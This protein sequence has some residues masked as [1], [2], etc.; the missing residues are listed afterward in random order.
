MDLTFLL[1]YCAHS[2]IQFFSDYIIP[3]LHSNILS[4]SLNIVFA[5]CVTHSIR[6]SN[7]MSVNSL[8]FS[9]YCLDELSFSKQQGIFT[10]YFFFLTSK[11][12]YC[13]TNS[14]SS[15]SKWWQ[16]ICHTI[17]AFMVRFKDLQLVFHNSS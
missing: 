15:F 16:W 6:T 17:L 11:S 5:F 10:W 7:S 4:L 9:I 2:N 12:Q 8:K 3:I 13:V 1:D 14:L